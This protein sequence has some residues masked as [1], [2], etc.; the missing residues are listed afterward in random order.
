MGVLNTIPW[1]RWISESSARQPAH[2]CYVPA[3]AVVPE[4]GA[5]PRLMRSAQE[6][7][8]EPNEGLAR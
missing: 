4:Q 1:N 7:D 5:Q 6:A 3:D 2:T 8:G